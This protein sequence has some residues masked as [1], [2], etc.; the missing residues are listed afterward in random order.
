MIFVD[1]GPFIARHLGSD[2]RHTD[3]VR[4]WEELAAGRDRLHTSN[5][6]LDEAFTLLAR[7]AGYRFAAERARNTYASRALLILR[8]DNSDEL[9][10]VGLFEKYADQAVSFTDCVS[11]ALMRRHRIARAFTYDRH[12]VAA[13]FELWQP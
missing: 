11:F 6:V 9:A 10:A 3:A 2:E 12:F 1:M 7:R 5:F 8:P 4:G 13:G